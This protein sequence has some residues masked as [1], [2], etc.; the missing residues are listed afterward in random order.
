MY[1]T[2]K[3]TVRK[4]YF[5]KIGIKNPQPRVCPRLRFPLRMPAQRFSGGKRDAHNRKKVG[6]CEEEV[7]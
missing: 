2:T 1:S 6:R 4:G 3:Q 7:S 5:P